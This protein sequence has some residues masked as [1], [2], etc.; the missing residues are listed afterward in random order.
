[1]AN[2]NFACKLE[3]LLGDYFVA[4]GQAVECLLNGTVYSEEFGGVVRTPLKNN[5]KI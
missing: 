4:S 2:S 5:Q 1:M 3:F